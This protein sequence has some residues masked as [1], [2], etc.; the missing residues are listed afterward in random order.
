MEQLALM[1]EKINESDLLAAVQN[2]NGAAF[3]SF[4]LQ[5]QKRVFSVALNFFGGNEEVAE[6]ITQQVFLKIFTSVENF[7]GEAKITTWLYRI[8]VNACIDEQRKT[9]RLS[10]FAD[11]LGFRE[12]RV[13][14]NQ[15]EKIHRREISGEVQKAVGTIDV[16]FRLP[17][18]LKYVENLSYREIAEVLDISEGTV[19][20]RLNRGHKLLARKLK[21]L[22]DEI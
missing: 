16:K 5:N 19:A 2:G 3:E 18:V 20:S 13:K 12:P 15:D 6:D 14:R 9:R 1:A 17:I 22:K 4:F 8:T 7:R 11:L 10:F 21:H